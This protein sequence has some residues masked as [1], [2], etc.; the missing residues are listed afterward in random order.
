MRKSKLKNVLINSIIGAIPFLPLN[1]S[2][3]EDIDIDENVDE[4]KKALE[5]ITDLNNDTSLN[6]L[7]S[8]DPEELSS[9]EKNQIILKLLNR[10]N[11]KI[12]LIPN[13][14]VSKEEYMRSFGAFKHEKGN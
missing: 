9:E 12:N 10:S 4:F 5:G 2:Y 11:G 13:I 1:Q 8:I 6:D 3:A 7:L 14:D